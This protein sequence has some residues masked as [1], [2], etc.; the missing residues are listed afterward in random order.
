MANIFGISTAVV[1]LLS[2]YVALKNKTAYEEEI[3]KSEVAT[4]NLAEKK[5]ELSDTEEELKKLPDDLSS[6]EAEATEL[7]QQEATLRKANEELKAEKDAKAATLESN[8]AKLTAI[9][10][11]SGQVADVKELASQ[12]KI[13]DQE[14]E[15]LTQDLADAEAKLANLTAQSSQAQASANAV[16]VE[17]DRQANNESASTLNTRVRSYYPTWGFVTLAGGNNVGVVAK[18]TLDVVR[19]GQ[20]IA[21]L[22]VTTVE[23]SSASASVIPDTLA[24]DA[25]IQAGDRVVPGTKVEKTAPAPAKN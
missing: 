15:T 24:A 2:A 17:L 5:S 18:S 13:A 7:S 1:L 22:L 10:E 14:L 8:K 20:T 16:K 6:V 23:S 25:T 3:K 9:R 4:H 19:D 11:Q 21:K 12:L